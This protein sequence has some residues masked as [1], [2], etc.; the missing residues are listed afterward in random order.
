MLVLDVIMV[1]M[2]GKR[3]MRVC[4]DGNMQGISEL[5]A[6]GEVC[7]AVYSKKRLNFKSD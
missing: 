7:V 5:V 4:F 1:Q 2:A 6:I 3:I